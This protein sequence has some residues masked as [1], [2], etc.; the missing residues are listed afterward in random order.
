MG[1]PAINYMDFNKSYVY[2]KNFPSIMKMIDKYL[3]K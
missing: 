3:K 1:F 2:F